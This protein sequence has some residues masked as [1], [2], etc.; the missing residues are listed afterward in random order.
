MA[1]GLESCVQ[2]ANLAAC[3]KAFWT[4]WPNA[5][6]VAKKLQDRYKD[7]PGGAL[8]EATKK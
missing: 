6:E 2:C 5:F 8:K 3:D 4:E 7:Q 1:G